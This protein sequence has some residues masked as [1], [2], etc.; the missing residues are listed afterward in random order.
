MLLECPKV[1]VNILTNDRVSALGI[2]LRR[3][4]IEAVNLILAHP[5]VDVNLEH[6]P[7]KLPLLLYLIGLDIKEQIPK[8]IGS[9]R[10]QL[11]G[12][13]QCSSSEDHCS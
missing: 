6:G 3:E 8:C 2:A 11:A 1:D 4:N 5:E 7:N 10:L 13:Y 12:S 9:G